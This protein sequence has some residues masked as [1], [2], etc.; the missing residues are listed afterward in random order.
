MRHF[1]LEC[2]LLEELRSEMVEE[3]FKEGVSI[4]LGEQAMLTEVKAAPIV[5]KFMIASGLLGQFQSVDSVAMGKEKGEEEEQLDHHDPIK[6]MMMMMMMMMNSLTRFSS[7]YI[8]AA[9]RGLRPRAR[10]RRQMM[11]HPQY[12]TTL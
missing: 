11:A 8:H 7:L 5:A 9:M 12:T 4:T 1:L 3:L 10:S 2:P 6:M